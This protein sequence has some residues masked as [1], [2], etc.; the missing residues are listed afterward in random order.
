MVASPEL[1]AREALVEVVEPEG[2]EVLVEQVGR[3]E[4][5]AP[6]EELPHHCQ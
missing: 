4:Q 1:V 6:I 2:P 3:G 5:V